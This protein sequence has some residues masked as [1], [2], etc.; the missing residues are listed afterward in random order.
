MC[1]HVDLGLPFSDTLRLGII[2]SD[3]QIQGTTFIYV[4]LQEKKTFDKVHLVDSV[5]VSVV[6]VVVNGSILRNQVNVLQEEILHFQPKIQFM[7]HP[8]SR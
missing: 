7:L 5:L 1:K 4:M 2:Y 6:K 8:P 3:E